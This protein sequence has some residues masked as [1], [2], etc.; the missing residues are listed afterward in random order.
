MKYNSILATV[1]C[2]HFLFHLLQ[3]HGT[4][5][6][7]IS[8]IENSDEA[9][10]GVTPLNIIGSY[11]N[12]KIMSNGS[13]PLPFLENPIQNTIQEMQTVLNAKFEDPAKLYSSPL[14]SPTFGSPKVS[15]NH[16]PSPQF[17]ITQILS[18]GHEPSPE[19]ILD[20]YSQDLGICKTNNPSPRED[21]TLK[22][23]MKLNKSDKKHCKNQKTQKLKTNMNKKL[24]VKKNN[25]KNSDIKAS[26]ENRLKE[27]M[28]IY[29]G[30]SKVK[31]SKS[32]FNPGLK[33]GISKNAA[34]KSKS[35]ISK[36]SS[37]ALIK[38]TKNKRFEYD[39]DLTAHNTP[40]EQRSMQSVFL[41]SDVK[42]SEEYI[43]DDLMNIYE[44]SVKTKH[45]KFYSTVDSKSVTSKKVAAKS[46]LKMSKSSSKTLRN[47]SKKKLVIQQDV[48]FSDHYVPLD[49]MS[50]LSM[51]RKVKHRKNNDK[52]VKKQ[53][54]KAKVEE[55]FVSDI[56]IN[57]IHKT[58]HL[59]NCDSKLNKFNNPIK[60][61]KDQKQ[62]KS[63][64]CNDN[65]QSKRIDD[66]HEPP[67]GNTN[68]IFKDEPNVLLE[69]ETKQNLKSN[70]PNKNIKKLNK[71]SKLIEMDE[72]N[73][74]REQHLNNNITKESNVKK[75]FQFP[76]GDYDMQN[77]YFNEVIETNQQ[78]GYSTTDLL[79]QLSQLHYSMQR[80]RPKEFE[81]FLK[82]LPFVIGKSTNKSHNL[83]VNIQEA[84]SLIKYNV[85]QNVKEQSNAGYEYDEGTP[86]VI[87]KLTS[88]SV[89]KPHL[90]P[91][92][93]NNRLY[94]IAE[95]NEDDTIK[96]WEDHPDCIQANVDPDNVRPR[97]SCLTQPQISYKK[98]LRQIFRG[99]T[100]S[101]EFSGNIN[102]MRQD[103]LQEQEVDSYFTELWKMLVSFSKEKEELKK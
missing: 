3:I 31:C 36:S 80:N 57:K 88:K 71:Q 46:E 20:L 65:C 1:D 54:L 100:V 56:K 84:L 42:G 61:I 15:S 9:L 89:K 13:A 85:P 26:N 19:E 5:N 82:H 79:D 29:G 87:S 55:H 50:R 95:C 75:D 90:C 43:L 76:G 72:R 10:K 67:K 53:N 47:K 44:G 74:D 69:Y 14:I 23:S 73:F 52:A 12:D 60:N 96:T 2:W 49:Q 63:Q 48:E 99:N 40:L 32:N 37:K 101:S 22:Q 81:R 34:T 24:D 77:N 6:F 41:N 59:N 30:S 4:N 58:M 18:P 33:S 83:F 11:D 70:I 94:A 68:I 98:V 66:D 25:I 21:I 27:L 86:S 97:C 38:K 17:S 93:E 45:H 62:I 16:E 64:N 102:S 8:N 78:L 39:S 91:V 103:I 35:N 7:Q 92:L 28:N 51:S